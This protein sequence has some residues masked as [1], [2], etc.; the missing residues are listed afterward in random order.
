[1]ASQARTANTQDSD[2]PLDRE[3]GFEH[4][5]GMYGTFHDLYERCGGVESV[6]WEMDRRSSLGFWVTEARIP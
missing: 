6:L 1:M 4:L 2:T 5:L 3:A